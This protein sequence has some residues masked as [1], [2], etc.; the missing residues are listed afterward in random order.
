MPFAAIEAALLER[1][2]GRAKLG[3]YARAIKTLVKRG[4]LSR[5]ELSLRAAVRRDEVISRAQR[6]A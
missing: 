2:F 3:A 4:V 6:A 5:E 1:H